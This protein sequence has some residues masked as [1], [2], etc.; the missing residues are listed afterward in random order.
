[1]RVLCAQEIW[2][3]L[4]QL[5]INTYYGCK[6]PSSARVGRHFSTAVVLNP[7]WTGACNL[8]LKATEDKTRKTAHVYSKIKHF[9]G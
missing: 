3:H 1:M 7:I 5:S 2:I 9:I 8:C 6:T 4:H